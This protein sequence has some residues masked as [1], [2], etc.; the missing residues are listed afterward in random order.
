MK[1]IECKNQKPR[2]M[3][4]VLFLAFDTDVKFGFLNPM[5]SLAFN[6]FYAIC[7]GGLYTIHDDVKYWMPLPEPPKP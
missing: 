4:K 6:H 5:D 2:Y 7:S 1:W 3:E